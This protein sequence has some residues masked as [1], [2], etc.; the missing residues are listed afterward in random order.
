M[1]RLYLI[2]HCIYVY[3]AKQERRAYEIYVTDRLKAI[4]D[5]VAHV[6]GGSTAEKRYMDF[7]E[8]AQPKRATEDNRTAEQVIS[9]ISEKLERLGGNESI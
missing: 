3:N 7:L 8:S 1:G 4:N 6:F 5:S 2:E 9:S